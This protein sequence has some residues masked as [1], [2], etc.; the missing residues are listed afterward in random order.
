MC[1]SGR[2]SCTEPAQHWLP[3]PPD[4][5][6]R[7]R[8]VSQQPQ[9]PIISAALPTSARD[10]HPIELQWPA[11]SAYHMGHPHLTVS[12]GP[13]PPTAR[14]TDLSPLFAHHSANTTRHQ[15]TSPSCTV[16]HAGS[17]IQYIFL[18]TLSC[19]LYL[20]LLHPVP[21]TH[22]SEPHHSCR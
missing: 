21:R 9:R 7:V 11:E 13:H 15:V 16:I 12:Y 2:C 1:S 17:I 5:N 22:I 8:M 20:R 3:C 18:Y 6:S 4:G 14:L 19:T 10:K